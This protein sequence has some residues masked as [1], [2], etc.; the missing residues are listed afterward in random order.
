M[1]VTGGADEPRSRRYD[2]QPP[3][4]IMAALAERPGLEVLRD[5]AAGRLPQP[6]MAATMGF[7][8]AEVDD[9]RAVMESMP[10]AWQANPMGGIH[11]G[12]ALTLLDSATGCATGTTLAAGQGYTT[13]DLTTHM[14]RPVVPD[15]PLRCEGRVLHRGRRLQTAYAEVLDDTGRLVAHGTAALMIL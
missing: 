10:G 14:V 15:T 1:D 11:G 3:T 5:V 7:R 13:V 8:I 6:P 12:V 9:G 2:W 4:A